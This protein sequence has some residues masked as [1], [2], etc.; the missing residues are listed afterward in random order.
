MKKV[1]SHTVR[2]FQFKKLKEYISLGNVLLIAVVAKE[3]EKDGSAGVL[4]DD[5]VMV[6]H[7]CGAG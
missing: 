4:M 2:N 7:T 3:C 6:N 1:S 5:M